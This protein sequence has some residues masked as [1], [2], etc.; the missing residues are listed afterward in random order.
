MVLFH[1]MTPTLATMAVLSCLT[2][3]LPLEETPLFLTPYIKAGHIMEAVKASKVVDPCNTTEPNGDC[4]VVIPESYAGLITVNKFLGNHLFFWFF[5]SQ[6]NKLAP[7]LIWLNGGPGISSMMGLLWEN[8]PLQPGNGT[9]KKDKFKARN[10]SWVG[11][12]SMLYIDNPVFTG[13]SYSSSRPSLTQEE[14]GNDL[15]EF[16]QQFY[17]LFP[18]LLSNDLFIGGQSY[19]GKYVPVLAH[20]IHSS[21]ETGRE[22]IP[23]RGIY[24]GGPL[25]A[26]EIM[27]P[28]NFEFLYSVGAVSEYQRRKVQQKIQALVEKYRARE[29]TPAATIEKIMPHI[30]ELPIP[31]YDN[32]VTGK[33]PAH[34]RITAIMKSK[35]MQKALH[36]GNLDF[37]SFNKTLFSQFHSDILLHV[38]DKLE[39]L[40]DS[41]KYKVLIFS[42][43]CDVV[44]SV[45]MVE[46]GLMSLRWHGQEDYKNASRTFWYGHS[47]SS[48]DKPLYGYFSQTK[49]LL[50]RVVVR[51]AGHQTPHDQLD[52]S[53]EMMVQ[54]VRH[55]CVHNVRYVPVLARRI[56]LS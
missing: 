55:G 10:G 30:F 43:D 13:Y 32:Y 33:E 4:E 16:V 1:S 25:F 54:F 6:E 39:E 27:F 36:L 52:I 34:N 48:D 7:L 3:G 37:I 18:Y 22:P 15:Y 2:F 31:S 20:R 19:A 44:V 29:L 21:R 42:G 49:N 53:R 14:Y 17:Q 8:G 12:F 56:R 47:N 46:A 28:E 26:P 9:E 24:I 11:P 5:P 41:K 45:A 23:L 40:L 51:G 50:C 38:K 35:R